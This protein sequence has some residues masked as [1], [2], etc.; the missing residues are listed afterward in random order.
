M[1]SVETNEIYRVAWRA[2]MWATTDEIGE[3]LR[4]FLRIAINLIT[5]TMEKT[6]QK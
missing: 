2:T 3:T 6:N 5:R 1:K 4:I